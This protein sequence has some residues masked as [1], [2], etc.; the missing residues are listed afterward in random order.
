[1]LLAQR[2]RSKRLGQQRQL[3]AMDRYFARSRAKNGPLYA[4]EISQVQ[5]CEQPIRSV[6]YLIP[7]NINLNPARFILQM[8]KRGFAHIPHRHDP[9]GYTGRAFFS[10]LRM[11][12]ERRTATLSA[13]RLLFIAPKI[14]GKLRRRAIALEPLLCKRVV[15]TR[16]QRGQLLQ[17][18]RVL[19]SQL[20]LLS[21]LLIFHA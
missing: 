19:V 14:L 11:I 5:V 3:L 18:Q 7:P 20:F 21:L 10:C 6:P 1:I 17:P 13:L 16:A 12:K 4:Q 15:T 8:R 9:A 2:Q